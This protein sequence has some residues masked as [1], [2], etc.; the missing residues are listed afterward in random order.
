MLRGD[1]VADL[2]HRLSQLG[3][4][5]GQV[6]GIFGEQTAVALT[7]FQRNVGLR[8]DGIVGRHTLNE[9]ERL[10][11]RAGASSLVSAVRERL[12]LVGDRPR[13]LAGRRVAV[14]E[15]GGFSTGTASICRGLRDAGA[16]AALAYSHRD[17]SRCAAAANAARVDCVVGLRLVAG[18]PTCRTSYYRGFR[19]ESAASRNLAELIQA[20]LPKALGL[21]DEGISGMSLPILR[22]TEMP[23]VEIELGAPELV[24]PRTAEL[25]RVVVTALERWTGADWG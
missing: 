3:F 10:S 25:A 16:G 2:Q 13:G 6:D 11:M 1:D 12:A 9:L 21:A 18:P 7:E 4:D 23:A 24:V 22:E 5:T 14:V 15:P 20:E 17:P 8:A 19:Y